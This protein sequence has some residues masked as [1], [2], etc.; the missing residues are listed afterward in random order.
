MSY[1]VKNDFVDK[2]LLIGPDKFYNFLLVYSVK[3][4]VKINS[5]EEKNINSPELELLDY[6]DKFLALYRRDGSA[7]YLELSNVFRK[8]A[9]KIYRI[10]LRKKMITLNGRFLN[11]V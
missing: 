4:I 6:S 5:K 8:A 11:S 3:K 9:H 10:M 1:G 2:Y 7:V